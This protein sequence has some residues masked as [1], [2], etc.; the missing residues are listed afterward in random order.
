MKRVLGNEI[1]SGHHVFDPPVINAF[2]VNG[3]LSRRDCPTGL[4]PE[5]VVFLGPYLPVKLY[6]RPH[7]TTTRCPSLEV[8]HLS[9]ACLSS[10]RG[11]RTAENSSPCPISYLF[12]LLNNRSDRGRSNGPVVVLSRLAVT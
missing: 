5:I 12:V 6:I 7:R 8:S 10:R 11:R 1:I 9:A 3:A 2:D 4:V